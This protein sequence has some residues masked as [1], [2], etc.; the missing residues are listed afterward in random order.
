VYLC[1]YLCVYVWVC[2]SVE[3]VVRLCMSV[4]MYMYMYLC[5]AK[6]TDPSLV[7]GV[8]RALQ[9]RSLFSYAPSV[10]HIFLLVNDVCCCSLCFSDTCEYSKPRVSFFC[11]VRLR[12]YVEVDASLGYRDRSDC[13][14]SATS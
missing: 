7:E 10:P 11:G 12:V 9:Q 2:L 5:L 8:L 4:Y 6:E 3:V 14:A 1:V 13:V